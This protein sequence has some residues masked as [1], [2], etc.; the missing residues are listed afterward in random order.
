V[1]A[2]FDKWTKKDPEPV[3]TVRTFGA[4]VKIE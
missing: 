3:S 2:L 1:Y 4:K